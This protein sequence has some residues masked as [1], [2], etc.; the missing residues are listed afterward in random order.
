MAFVGKASWR[1]WVTTNVII[2]TW[3]CD[4]IDEAQPQGTQSCPFFQNDGNYEVECRSHLTAED[5][6]K[7]HQSYANASKVGQPPR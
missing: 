4:L 2:N 5:G 3:N 6:T 7:S 1:N